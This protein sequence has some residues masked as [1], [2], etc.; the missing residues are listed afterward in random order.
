MLVRQLGMEELFMNLTE[1][2]Y[3]EYTLYL[4]HEYVS[5]KN[6]NIPEYRVVWRK[7]NE[8]FLGDS[9]SWDA[10]KHNPIT[11]TVDSDFEPQVSALFISDEYKK[12]FPTNIRYTWF[13]K[14]NGP[15]RPL[16]N[17]YQNPPLLLKESINFVKSLDHEDSP[18]QLRFDNFESLTYGTKLPF[19][20]VPNDVELTP[21]S[22][23]E[24]SKN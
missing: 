18:L 3:L 24:V 8:L 19:V 6:K 10:H 14:Y 15:F 11:T 23:I 22:L 16:L 17:L 4:F 21:V 20:L 12:T 2:N 13:K 5:S 7:D 9:L 1:A